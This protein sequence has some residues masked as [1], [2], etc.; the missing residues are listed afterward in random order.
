MSDISG[1]IWDWPTNS[2]GK[3][4]A[5]LEEALNC[6]ICSEMFKNPQSL[7]KC[8]HHFCYECISKHF[9][10]NL[11]HTTSNICPVC[12]DDANLSS[13]R[14]AKLL[15][16]ILFIFHSARP[17]LISICKAEILPNSI[18]TYILEN[19]STTTS[20]CKRMPHTSFHGQSREKVKKAI[21]N[22]CSN[23]KIKLRTDGAKD[24]LERRHRDFIHLNNA[25]TDATRPMSLEQVINEIN[26]RDAEKDISMKNMNKSAPLI[27]KIRNG[28]EPPIVTNKYKQIIK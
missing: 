28:E 1:S 11:N 22:L 26:R 18:D 17:D 25:Q 3:K 14:S 20:I 10:K 7:N 15:A 13:I 24:I 9:D 16:D 19:K 27:E 6:P 4:L 8:G 5:K 23:S 21:E 2:L 12:R